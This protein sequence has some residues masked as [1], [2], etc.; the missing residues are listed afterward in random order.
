MLCLLQVFIIL[1]LTRILGLAGPYLR[2]P[3]IVFEIIAGIMLGPS[4]LGRI[5]LFSR[6]IFDP[7]GP[8]MTGLYILSNF[9]LIFYLYLVGLE[10][11]PIGMISSFHQT[12]P[13]ALVGMILPFSLGALISNLLYGILMEEATSSS[14]VV[15]LYPMS[16][17][18]TIYS[19]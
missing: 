3:R 14:F 6:S 15:C 5:S 19:S 12:G 11:N 16:Y 1:V 10:V 17:T 4:G 13:I 7:S 9:A 8:S 18:Y 2:Q